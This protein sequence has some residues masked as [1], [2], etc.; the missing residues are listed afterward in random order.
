MND[1]HHPF[2]GMRSQTRVQWLHVVKIP[3]KH[4]IKHGLLIVIA[5]KQ[6]SKRSFEL[7]LISCLFG[8]VTL[9][10]SLAYL[11]L[12]L[13]LTL[14]CF[15]SVCLSVCLSACLLH[16]L[17]YEKLAGQ[18]KTYHARCQ[19]ASRTRRSQGQM[20]LHSIGQIIGVT[21]KEILAHVH[22]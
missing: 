5:N 13:S 11:I 4:V 10:L 8:P 20:M 14:A 18:M 9:S 12:V 1:G 2:G 19:L 16:F 6:T 22:T 17:F 21:E 3:Q 7:N 15:L